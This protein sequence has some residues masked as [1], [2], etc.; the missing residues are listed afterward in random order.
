MR[1]RNIHM[2]TKV[3][4]RKKVRAVKEDIEA[5]KLEQNKTARKT[6]NQR[7]NSWW[8]VALLLNNLNNYYINNN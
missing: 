7:Q 5:G 8:N 4:K 2:R 3:R 1:G 6:V